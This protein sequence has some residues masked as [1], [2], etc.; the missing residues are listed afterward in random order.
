MNRIMT[1]WRSS[2]NVSTIDELMTIAISRPSHED[3]TA[4][5][6][7]G[8]WLEQTTYT[9]GLI[10]QAF[11]DHHSFNVGKNLLINLFIILNTTRH[12][13]GAGHWI[14]DKLHKYLGSFL[15]SSV[16]LYFKH[17]H[18]CQ[19]KMHFLMLHILL[20]LD[21]NSSF[22]FFSCAF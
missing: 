20:Q 1:D 6:A 10:I 8:R 7:V 14:A 22:T 18:N 11:N 19:D 13:A 16:E 12:G 21:N 3:Y 9:A 2:L 15:L 4:V 17:E 5:L